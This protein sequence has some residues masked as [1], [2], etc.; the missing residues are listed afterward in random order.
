[1]AEEQRPNQATGRG[2]RTIY[3]QGPDEEE[4][5]DDL[6]AQ[7]TTKEDNGTT[8]T[9]PGEKKEREEKT[10]QDRADTSNDE[11]ATEKERAETEERNVKSEKEA[12]RAHT[13]SICKEN[14]ELREKLAEIFRENDRREQRRTEAE[15]HYDSG[16]GPHT[17]PERRVREAKPAEDEGQRRSLIQG[18]RDREQRTAKM[19]KKMVGK[20]SGSADIDDITMV[21]GTPRLS[22]LVYALSL[23][24]QRRMGDDYLQTIVLA[25]NTIQVRDFNEAA[26]TILNDCEAQ[27]VSRKEWV[28]WIEAGFGRQGATAHEVCTDL[29]YQLWELTLKKKVDLE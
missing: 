11:Q 25:S 8:V 22:Q 13:A 18:D 3:I 20:N 12:E 14:A 27:E 6:E 21:K 23:R 19:L 2:Q 17:A 5:Q 9:A 10:Q 7:Q 28:A 4:A 16:I 26:Q 1:M 29:H 15:R 24:G